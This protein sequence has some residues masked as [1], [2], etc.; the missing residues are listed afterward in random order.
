MALKESKSRKCAGVH[1]PSKATKQLRALVRR[2]GL[3]MAYSL[4]LYH[5]CS[6]AM[7]G[8]SSRTSLVGVQPPSRIS[9]SPPRA[10]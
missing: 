1:T 9:W 3:A 4:E 8:N 5:A 10:K 6:V 2:N 7:S